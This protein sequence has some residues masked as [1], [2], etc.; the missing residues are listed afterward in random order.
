MP[1]G[2]ILWREGSGKGS[3]GAGDERSDWRNRQLLRENELEK[4]KLLHTKNGYNE[5]NVTSMKT[6]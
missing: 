4:L 3:G 1:F 5:I 6:Q 2:T